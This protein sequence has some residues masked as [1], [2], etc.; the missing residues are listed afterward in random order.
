MHSNIGMLIA[1]VIAWAAPESDAP[2][3]GQSITAAGE[4]KRGA[5]AVWEEQTFRDL[6]QETQGVGL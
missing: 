1:M 3:A 5:V 2:R 6:D 4:V